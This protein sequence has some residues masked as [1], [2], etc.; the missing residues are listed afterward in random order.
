MNIVI[1]GAGRAG[2]SFAAALRDVGHRV[3][4]MHHGDLPVELDASLDLVILAVPDDA[5]ALVAPRLVLGANTV[6]AHLSGARGRDVLGAHPRVGSLHPL[7][8][9]PDASLGAARLRGAVY[10]VVG[11]PLLYEVVAT[12]GGRIVEVLEDQ[13]VLYH[14][15]AVA[16]AN[17]VVAL[18]AHVEVLAQE[19]GLELVDF[20]DLARQAL[21]DVDV[22]GP[23][24]ALT[25]PAARGDVAT[26][27]AHLAA[28]PEAERATY[29]VLAQRAQRIVD[30][31]GAM[32]WNA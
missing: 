1:V 20:L 23:R 3:T 10:S 15:T 24:R 9:L 4:L 32:S 14:A 12:L 5:I 28:V 8:I 18:M 25:G 27:R 11:D 29:A 17:H 30:H 22:L 2:T 13:R 7:A 19:V 31:D 21:D 16:A 26:I 6:I